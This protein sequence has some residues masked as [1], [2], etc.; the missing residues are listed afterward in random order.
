MTAPEFSRPVRID[1][2]GEQ[3]RAMEIAAEEAERVALA[4]ALR[5]DRASTGSRPS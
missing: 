4:R 3:P 5:P 2:V 1:T